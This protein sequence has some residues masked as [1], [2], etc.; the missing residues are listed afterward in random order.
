MEALQI[1]AA[2]FFFHLVG[3][4]IDGIDPVE[5]HATLEAGTGLLA[6]YAQQFDFL[7]EIL[8][9]LVNMGKAADLPA[10]QVPLIVTRQAGW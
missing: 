4:R 8:D 2:Q 7:D 3:H 10:I 9:I 5:T 6:R 1:I